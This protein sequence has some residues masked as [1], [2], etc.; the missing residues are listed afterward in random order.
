MSHT[1]FLPVDSNF[2]PCAFLCLSSC[3]IEQAP[4]QPRGK[5]L[6]HVAPQKEKSVSLCHHC[7]V[8]IHQTLWKFPILTEAWVV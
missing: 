2:S 5:L 6:L 3:H 7:A 1:F 8:I 4:I